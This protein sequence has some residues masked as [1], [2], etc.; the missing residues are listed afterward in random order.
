[1]IRAQ[2]VTPWAGLGSEASP[3]RPQL[4]DGHAVTSWRDVTGQ[5]AQNLTPSPNAFTIEITCS[6]AVLVDIDTAGYTIL[7]SEPI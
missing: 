5:P 3:F 1:M 2:V 4:A 6:E 7:W